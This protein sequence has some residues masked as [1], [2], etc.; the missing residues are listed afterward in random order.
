V[1]ASSIAWGDYDNDG[2]MD[3]C[4][5]GISDTTRI[6]K[7]YHNVAGV[8]IDSEVALPGVGYS[9]LEWAD[10]DNDGDLD[11]FV[12]GKM[13]NQ[14]IIAKIYNNDGGVFTDINANITPAY[15]GS[16]CWGDYNNDGKM[17]LIVSGINSPTQHSTKIYRNTPNGF[18]DS[19]ITLPQ[20]H[21]S[22]I[23]WGDYDNNSWLDILITGINET[24]QRISR[25]LH[26]LNGEFTDI[27]AGIIG[28]GNSAAGW[29][30]SD[31][32]GLLDIAIS[33][34]TTNDQLI[35]K[36][37]HNLGGSFQDI[38]ANLNGV[39]VSSLNWGDCDN[40]G[41]LDLLVTGGGSIISPYNPLSA[42]YEN[43]NSIFNILQSLNG[44]CFS[45]SGM[46]DYNNDGAIDILL[47]GLNINN[48]G[49]TML[50]ENVNT[51]LDSPPSSP[52]NLRINDVGDYLQFQ[53][54]TSTDPE[55]SAQSL[56][57]AIR[58]GSSP[59]ACDIV[60]PMALSN[61]NSLKPSLGYLNSNCSFL[62]SKSVFDSLLTYYWSC[63]AIDNSF[64]RSQFAPEE[65]FSL[66]TNIDDDSN[67]IIRVPLI[68][69]HPNPF[70]NSTTISYMLS[71]TDL[72]AVNIYNVKGEL[73]KSLS[74]S[75]QKQGLHNII[76]SGEDNN[77]K[78]VS[79]GI[80]LC[81]VT[82]N[83]SSKLHKM[84]LMK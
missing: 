17:D 50:Y 6:T 83:G 71:K 78:L 33:G 49:V 73:V 7:L 15:G 79:P 39:H 74:L 28:V 32:D 36:I 60:S 46:C 4:I 14:Q 21:S 20:V 25:V 26:N 27:N 24:G 29:G 35:T 3:V 45:S 55:Q 2:S 67:C 48:V 31:N 51:G 12:C 18:I 66:I 81:K 5:S 65:S 23:K 61:G 80:F 9:S 62:I 8:F 77:G 16:A 63:Q 13:S 64:K 52:S 34:R 58:I 41:D 30:D 42:I 19:E 38:N 22:S 40:D 11:L 76:W 84:M 75:I 1:F 44:V 54:D 57:Y 69:T 68:E 47:S 10:Y 72:V 82:I 43:N 37:Y 59:D 56:T 53:W 70:N